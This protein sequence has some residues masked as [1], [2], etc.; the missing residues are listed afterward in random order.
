MLLLLLLL[1][2]IIIIITY[3]FANNLNRSIYICG[4]NHIKRRNKLEKKEKIIHIERN[5]VIILSS[6]CLRA[7]MKIWIQKKYINILISLC[8]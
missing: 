1:L 8:K 7:I 3:L 6:N 4:L 2:L 5:S